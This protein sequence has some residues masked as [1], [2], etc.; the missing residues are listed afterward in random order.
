MRPQMAMPLGP[1]KNYFH[2]FETSVFWQLV[3]F[4]GA[5]LRFIPHAVRRGPG[6][7]YPPP[8][9]LTPHMLSKLVVSFS[10]L[11]IDLAFQFYILFLI[12][13]AFF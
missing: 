5:S 8:M 9:G 10:C 4:S 13:L 12:F 11:F 7:Q 2:R 6:A 1:G 3:T